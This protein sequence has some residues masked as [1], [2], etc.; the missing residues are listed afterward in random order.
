MV[1]SLTLFLGTWTLLLLNYSALPDSI[2][3]HF[4]VVG[5]PDDWAAK[6]SFMATWLLPTLM[7]ILAAGFA[8]VYRYPKYANLPTTVLIDLLPKEKR[9]MVILTIRS[10]IVSLS[11]IVL[12]LMFVLEYS[13]IATARGWQTGLNPWVMLA[14]VAL[15]L[16]TCLFYTV[17]ATAIINWAVKNKK[18]KK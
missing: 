4:N 14:I 10:M 9:Q 13:T 8:L 11:A 2:P 18:K 1:I 15:L 6:G 16:T 7:T 3:V 12:L 17:M 5:E